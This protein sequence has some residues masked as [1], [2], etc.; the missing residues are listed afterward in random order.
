MSTLIIQETVGDAWTSLLKSITNHG[1]FVYP[2]GLLYR[3]LLGVSLTVTDA[4]N[5]ILF[6]P[7]RKLAYKFM[8]AEWLWIWFG[9]E[10]VKTI[11]QY[12]PHISKFSDDGIKFA[13]AY[14]PRISKQVG[15]IE[16]TLKKDRDSRQAVMTIYT[17][18]PKPSKDI[19]CTLSVQFLIR[20]DRLHTIV[21]M[22]SSDAW[23][24]I[25]YD[26]FNFSMIG[27]IFAS[28][29]S[30]H[31]GSIT[32][33][34]GSSHVYENNFIAIDEVLN[35]KATT[36]RSPY[37]D[38]FPPYY[39]FDVLLKRNMRAS[40]LKP[41]AFQEPWTSYAKALT[42]ETNSDALSIIRRTI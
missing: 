20:D 1:S 4:H 22:R 38:G 32:F 13:G 28:L 11:S 39:M 31:V 9:M 18:N 33:N 2:R 30:V 19:P 14:G 27:N 17:P 29:L 7:K 21:T 41:E 24:G 42:A 6:H 35:S 25:P 40:V 5:N 12:N 8:V 37:L 34:L 36:Y 26:L 15:Y 3:E 23:L 10:D 16:D